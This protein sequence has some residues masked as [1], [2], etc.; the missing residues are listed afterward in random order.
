MG[1][2]YFDALVLATLF[3]DDGS[4]A[5]S[6][7]YIHTKGFTFFDVYRLAGL[8]HYNFG[9]VCTVQ[10]HEGRPV[11]YVTAESVSLFISIVKPHIHPRFYYKLGQGTF[12]D[13]I[14]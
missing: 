3:M 14:K 11:I 10:D 7:F 4:F 2:H 5:V 8:L 6:G 9:L 13:S 12:Q 1:L